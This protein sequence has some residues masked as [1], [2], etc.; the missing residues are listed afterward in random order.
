M[1][2]PDECLSIYFDHKKNYQTGQRKR[3]PRHIYADPIDPVVCLILALSIYSSIFLN[4]GTKDTSLFPGKNQYKK[5]A[6]YFGFIIVNNYI[7]EIKDDFG[8]DVKDNVVH[9]LRQGA[10]S[11][12]SLGS[13]CAPPPQVATNIR[14]GW[15]IGQRQDTYLRFK[16]AGDQYVGCVVSGLPIC[17]PNFTVLRPQFDCCVPDSEEIIQIVFP[18]IPSGLISAGRFLSAYILFHARV[19]E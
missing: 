1:E 8:V 13:T 17:F 7:E 6:K 18:S 2:W 10:A 3:G 4:I 14:A 12:V 11:Y 19:K 16:S 5:F 9:L 15:T